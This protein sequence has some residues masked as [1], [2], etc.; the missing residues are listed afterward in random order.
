MMTSVLRDSLGGNCMT[1][2]IA[3]C[4]VEKKNV[5]ESISTC[6]FAQRVALIKND[7]F[8]NEELDPKMMIEKLKLEI[9][10]LKDELS[11]AKGEQYESELTEEE[12]NRLITLVQSFIEDKDEEAVLSVGADMRKINYCFTL[13]K[14]HCVNNNENVK[15]KEVGT[16]RSSISATTSAAPHQSSDASYL[17]KTS[18]VEKLKDLILQ[19][20]NEINILV[21]MLKKE[22]ERTSKINPNIRTSST[23]N[24]QS[25]TDT[26]TSVNKPTLP[27]KTQIP[28]VVPDEEL[29]PILK[30]ADTRESTL[31]ENFKHSKQMAD[32]SIGRQEA[33]EIFKRDYKENGTIDENKKGLKRRYMDAKKLGEQ[34]NNARQSINSIKSELEKIKS[35]KAD[36]P[37][38]EEKEIKL[39]EHLDEEKRKYK[40]AFNQLKLL[41]TEIEHMQHLLEKSKVKLQKDFEIWWSEQSLNSNQSQTSIGNVRSA[42]K[43]PPLTP[44]DSTATKYMTSKSRNS[45]EVESRIAANFQGRSTPKLEMSTYSQNERNSSQG[46]NHSEK[47]ERELRTSRSL[48]NNTE[49]NM[50]FAINKDISLDSSINSIYSTRQSLESTR[51]SYSS[52]ANRSNT[53]KSSCS[54]PLTGDKKTD[55]DILAFMKARQELMRKSKHKSTS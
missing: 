33:F 36:I 47:S 24:M 42:W 20:D 43:T 27:K 19:R 15:N 10:Q 11:L 18:E 48:K 21:R 1:T 34:V 13:L 31:M 32:M 54:I 25:Y 41:K 52:N 5:D 16:A 28:P 46:I 44:I 29:S 55:D 7:A 40:S 14:K 4:S 30:Q 26:S 8:L 2:M 12:T 51:S 38:V 3:T 45:S 6:R 17:S 49:Q 23:Y 50:N 37:H 53:K 35:T 39:R 22:K 9:Q